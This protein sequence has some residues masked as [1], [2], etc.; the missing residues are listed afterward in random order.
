MMSTYES[1]GDVPSPLASMVNEKK[2]GSAAGQAALGIAGI[3][4]AVVLIMGQISLAITKGMAVH[5]EASVQHIREGNEVMESVI[6]RAAPSVELE[7]MLDKQSETLAN[8]RDAMVQTNEQLESI[9]VSKKQLIE[10]VGGMQSTSA[11]LASDVSS[12]GSSTA[13]MNSQLG[14]LPSATVR[15]HKQL[16]RINKDTSAINGE[17]AA[18]GRKMRAFGLPRAKGAPIK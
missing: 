8:T 13:D 18:I 6:E 14:T 9:L 5:L 17:L 1:A 10:V 7:K 4:L 3:I 11:S 16:A 2:R 12:L 15:T